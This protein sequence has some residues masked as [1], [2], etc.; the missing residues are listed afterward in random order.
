MSQAI[1]VMLLRHKRQA[2]FV[3]QL[4]G[5]CETDLAMDCIAEL[6]RRNESGSYVALKAY[7]GSFDIAEADD[8]ELAVHLRRLV[9]SAVNQTIFRLLGD[10]DPGLSKIIRNIKAGVVSLKTFN[11]MEVRGEGCI[12]PTLV[13]PL[14]HLPFM[15]NEGLTSLLMDSV[16][17]G[18]RTPHLL[19]ALACVLRNQSNCTRAIPL[20]RAA[21]VFR[22]VL[23]LKETSAPN[24]T[25]IVEPSREVELHQAI[26][27]ACDDVYETVEKKYLHTKGLPRDLLDSYFRAV[28]HF[29][30]SRLEGQNEEPTLLESLR[31]TGF[32]IAQEEYRR[33]HRQRV[34][35]LARL[36]QRETKKIIEG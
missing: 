20:V 10:L 24:V 1:A 32:C 21:M 2:D 4:G 14:P 15:S 29:L 6:F 13:D 16:R 17:G 35:Y 9:S 25:Q 34:E 18:E 5:I 28:R 22:E 27:K 12:A 30:I 19:A 26:D 23:A 36:V 11:E 33:V 3:A 31:T 7:F 8:A